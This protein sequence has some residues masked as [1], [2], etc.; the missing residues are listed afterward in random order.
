MCGIAGYWQPG[1][2]DTSVAERMIQR[3]RARGPDAAGTWLDQQAGV[4]LGHRRLAIVDLSPTGHQPMISSCGRYVLVYNGEIY[5]HTELRTELEQAGAS[6]SWRG[7]SD[8]ETLLVALQYWGMEATLKR[9]N[10]MFAFALWDGTERRLFLARDRMGEK[11]LYYGR[12]KTTF[13]FG[14]ELKALKAHPDWEGGLDRDVL[15]LFMRHNYVP[16]PRSIF[17]GIS[18]LPAAHYMV[19][20]D[21][22]KAIGQPQCYWNLAEIAEQGLATPF[23]AS[24]GELTDEL[25][26]L[27]SDAVGKR[28]MADVPLG[29][30]LSGGYDSTTVVAL[31]QKLSNQPVKTFAIGFHEKAYDEAHHARKV[32]N[33]LGTDHTE[34]YVTPEEAMAVIPRIPSLYDEPFSDSSQIPTLLVS[35]LARSRVTV[36]L[37]GDGGDELFYGYGRYFKGD[38]I[39]NK[40]NSLPL[41]LRKALSSLLASLPPQ[42]LEKLMNLLPDK[43]RINHLAD[44]MPSLLDLLVSRDGLALYRDLVSHTKQ[45]NQ[46]VLGANEPASLLSQPER[47]PALPSLRERMMYLDM[48]TYL[49]DDIL[50]KVDR[51]SMAVGLEVR[52]PLLDHRVAEFAWKVPTQYKHRDGGGKWLLRQLLYRH[53]PREMMDRPKM[54]FGVPIEHWLRGPLQ[55]WAEALLDEHRL[56][57]ANILN[58]GLVRKMWKEH[59]SGERSWHY[60]LWDILM[61]QSWMEAQIETTS[62]NQP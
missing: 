49:P 22:G 40:V 18:K 17:Q 8:T 48:M 30:F 57:E 20:R 62:Q 42:A 53:V 47:M 12:S 13:L 45:P 43:V 21:D 41:P 23:T 11:P 4:V 35:E 59:K 31:M 33:Y 55:D 10:G 32:A 26:T 7:H 28:M 15:A 34:L 24:A 37:S 27:L 29:A 36:S 2:Q 51:A 60:Y 56:R 46:L 38:R 3:I 61:F 39:W 14:S 9:L 16:A 52:V 19:I 5:N 6:P 25:E 44:R 50:T 58:P 54:G 1:V